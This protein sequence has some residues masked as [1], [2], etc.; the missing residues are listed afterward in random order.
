MTDDS[1]GSLKARMIELETSLGLLQHD[2]ESWN[3][4]IV[5]LTGRVKELEQVVQR[6]GERI[7]DLEEAASGQ[8]P[9]EKPPHY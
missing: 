5:W 8:I 6:L 3:E 9:N 4:T 7:A 2:C 1:P